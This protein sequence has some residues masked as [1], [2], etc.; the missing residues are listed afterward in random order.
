MQTD[1]SASTPPTG[2]ASRAPHDAFDTFLSTKMSLIQGKNRR[3]KRMH[4]INANY[5]KVLPASRD[6]R[7]LEIGPGL[8][9]AIEFFIGE[10]GYTNYHAI[11]VSAE[12]VDHCNNLVPGSCSLCRDTEG[13]LAQHAGRF[14]FIV[15]FHVLEHSPRDRLI[16]FARALHDALAPGGRLLVEVPNGLNLV[17][18]PYFA[19]G[20]LTHEWSFTT[21][22]LSQVL[23][24]GGFTQFRLG[25]CR[26]PLTGPARWLHY[27]LQSVLNGVQVVLLR[28][29]LPS[30]RPIVAHTMWALATR[31]S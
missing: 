1:P 19:L 23:R 25:G 18:G 21:E 14:D 27:G 11:D 4:W 5:R 13:Y 17:T 8:G 24:L 3:A 29:Y 26:V 22:S 16:P 10:K 31:D 12:V 30:Y 28:A 6:A 2:G 7:I 15:L 20:E 9:E